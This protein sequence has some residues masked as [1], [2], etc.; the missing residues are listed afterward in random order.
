MAKNA[1]ESKLRSNSSEIGV[2]FRESLT[3][4]KALCHSHA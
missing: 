1:V 2:A 3:R 4:L